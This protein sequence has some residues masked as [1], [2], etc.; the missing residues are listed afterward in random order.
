MPDH[1]DLADRIAEIFLQH[2]HLEVPNPDTDLV[3]ARLLDSLGFVELVLSLQQEFGLVIGTDD[4][5]IENFR[6]IN[7]IVAFVSERSAVQATSKLGRGP[8][9]GDASRI[10]EKGSARSRDPS[11]D[12]A[13]AFQPRVN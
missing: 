7:R 2:L 5:E 10:P 8:A 4:L 1:A 12:L 6:S 9:T 3:E 11:Y 13:I